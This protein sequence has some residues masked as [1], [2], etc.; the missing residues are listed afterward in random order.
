MEWSGRAPA[1]PATNAGRGHRRQGARHVTEARHFARRNRHRYRQEL[2]PHR[3]PES[4]RCYRAAAEV[5][6]W[7]VAD[8]IAGTAFVRGDRV[9]CSEWF[10]EGEPPPPKWQACHMRD[11]DPT[12][13]DSIYRC[14]DR[15]VEAR[16]DC[17]SAANPSRPAP[18]L[19]HM[20]D[21]DLLHAALG[22]EK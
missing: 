17:G 20:S 6:A 10:G 15:L 8:V 2:V 1:L 19:A 4:A 21:I 22:V 14:L 18:Y 3:W 5:V 16:R 13:Q 7:P 12:E 9:I 11:F